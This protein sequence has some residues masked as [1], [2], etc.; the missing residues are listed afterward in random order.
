MLNDGRAWICSDVRAPDPSKRQRLVGSAF[1]GR[2]FAARVCWFA[3]GLTGGTTGIWCSAAAQNTRPVPGLC[4][5][6]H[7]CNQ[8]RGGS[9]GHHVRV[10]CGGA[11][12]GSHTS[13]W[14]ADDV[15][16]LSVAAG[17][18][19][20]DGSSRARDLSTLFQPPVDIMF[21][22]SYA[23]VS[24]VVPKGKLMLGRGIQY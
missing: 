23:D 2:A 17:P 4:G 16:V 3:R 19:V 22:G 1:D 18:G 10:R 21:Q 8:R 14:S 20:D 13:A 9:A 15:L 12:A 5:R 6:E 11:A 24:A 7:R